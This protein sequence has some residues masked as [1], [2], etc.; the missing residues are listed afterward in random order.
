MY[1]VMSQTEG[2]DVKAAPETECKA[3]LLTQR[4]RGEHGG[5]ERQAA[6]G[7]AHL[8]LMSGSSLSLSCWK[9]VSRGATESEHFDLYLVALSF[10]HRNVEVFEHLLHA[11]CWSPG[12]EKRETVPVLKSLAVGNGR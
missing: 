8:S 9:I 3:V 12:K 5:D 6:A 7:R 4:T 10:M 2:A 11:Q 1:N